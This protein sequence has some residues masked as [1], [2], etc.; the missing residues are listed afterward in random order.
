MSD[1]EIVVRSFEILLRLLVLGL[2]FHISR[3]IKQMSKTKDNKESSNFLRKF[4]LPSIIL[5]I[6][7]ALFVVLGIPKVFIGRI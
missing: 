7:V 4:Y 2:L 5:I 3:Q 1:A 6:I